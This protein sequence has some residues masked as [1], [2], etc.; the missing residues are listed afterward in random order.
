MNFLRAPSQHHP[1]YLWTAFAY[2]LPSVSL[3]SIQVVGG[4]CVFC[5]FCFVVLVCLGGE[6][7]NGGGG[8]FFCC[9]SLE[10][11][12]HPHSVLNS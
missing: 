12:P 5:A 9:C 1:F 7:G 4:V 6:G 2:L 3:F 10:A 8:S 11:A